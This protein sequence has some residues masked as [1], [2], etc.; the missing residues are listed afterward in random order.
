MKVNTRKVL[1][2]DGGIFKAPIKKNKRFVTIGL[3][4]QIVD[5]LKLD[6]GYVFCTLVDGILQL[7]GQKPDV[8][9]PVA[10]YNSDKFIK[11]D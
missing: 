11:Q 6:N 4:L 7:S 1:Q 2:F 10:F 3:P 8:T 5:S 9:I